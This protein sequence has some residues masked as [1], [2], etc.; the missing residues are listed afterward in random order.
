M[1]ELAATLPGSA[2]LVVPRTKVKAFD[3]SVNSLSA[4]DD[5][6]GK[7]PVLHEDS[8][9]RTLIEQSAAYLF[10]VARREY[11]GVYVTANDPDPVA[12]V[13]LVGDVKVTLHGLSRILSR[14]GDPANNI[15]F[16]F[17][18]IASAISSGRSTVLI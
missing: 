7:F 11:D 3:L 17:E 16:Y 4:L 1:S 12:F 13:V 14:I 18:G 8:E 2:K 5:F 15:P 9:I 10:E 6:L